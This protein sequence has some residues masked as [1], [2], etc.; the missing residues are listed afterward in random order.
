MDEQHTE[1]IGEVRENPDISV[2]DTSLND[3]AEEGKPLETQKKKFFLPEIKSKK[4]DWQLPEE[5][6]D[7]FKERCQSHMSDR[8]LEEF[9]EVPVPSNLDYPTKLDPFMKALL[10][11]K[12]LNKT[13]SVDDEMQKLHSRLFQIMGPLGKAWS[14][15]QSITQ[16]DEE[17]GPDPEEILKD[18]NSTIVLLGQTINKMAYE[19]RLSVL[20]AL[21]DAK[22]AKRQIKD[23]LDDINKEKKC[24]FGD[25]F[26]KHIKTL[27]KAQESA[28]KL[29]TKAGT[30]RK[31]P[32][33]NSR[34][35]LPSSSSNNSSYSSRTNAGGAS[36]SKN[37][38]GGF[39]WKRGK[40]VSINC[41]KHSN[42]YFAKSE[43]CK[44][45]SKKSLSRKTSRKLFR[46]GKIKEFLSELENNKFRP[47][48]L[49]NS[50]RLEVTHNRQTSSS[51]GA[52]RN[53]NVQLRATGSGQGNQNNAGKGCPE[54]GT[55][56]GKSVPVK[57][58]CQTQKRGEKISTNNKFETLEQVHA[59]HPFQNGG[60][61]ECNGSLKP[62]RLHDQD[63]SEGSLLACPNSQ[64][65]AEVS[66]FS[67]EGEIVRDAS[68]SFWNR[69]RTKNIYKIN[70]STSD[71]LEEI[72][73][74]DHCLPGR[75][76]N[77]KQNQGG[78]IGGQRFCDF[79]INPAGAHN[80]LGKISVDSN[81]GNRVSR[82]D[83]KQH[84]NENLVTNREDTESHRH[85]PECIEGKKVDCKVISQFNRETLLYSSCSLSSASMD[86]INATEPHQSST[87]T[88]GLRAGTVSIAG[89]DR[90]AQLVD[91]QFDA[92]E[93]L[94]N[95][96]RKPRNDYI[97]RCI[98]Q[99]GLGS[100]TGRRDINRGTLDKAGKNVPS[101]KRIGTTSRRNGNKNICK[102][103]ESKID[104]H[105]YRQHDST[106][107]L[108]QERGDKKSKTD[109]NIKKNLE[110][111][112]EPGNNANCIL[113]SITGEQTSRLEIPTKTELK[114]VGIV[115]SN[116]SQ[117]SRKM[118]E[119]RDRL[120][121]ITNNEK[122]ATV[123]VSESR[124]EL[125][126]NKCFV[127]KLGKFPL[128][129]PSI[130]SNRKSSQAYSSEDRRESDGHRTLMARTA[131][132]P[133]VA[134]IV[135]RQPN[136]SPSIAMC[137]KKSSRG[138][139]STI[140]KQDLS[141]CGL[142]SIRQQLEKKGISKGASEIMLKSKR[143]ST[144]QA[145]SSP[146]NKWVLWCKQQRVDPIDSP[147]NYILD[148][149][150]ELYHEGLQYRTINVYRSAI[151]AYHV[152]IGDIPVGQTK[153]VCT[154]LS[155]IDNLRPPVP[156]YTVIWEVEVVI[157]FLKT[158]IPEDD[159]SNKD[160]TLKVVMLMA[161]T[162]IKR[163]SELQMLD[164]QHMAVGE[165]KVIF[166]PSERPKNCKKKGG[167][168]PPVTFI[169]SGGEL[170]PV[171][172]IKSYLKRTNSW[173]KENSESKFFLSHI[174]PH[175]RVSASTIGRWL[176]TVLANVGVDISKF[177]A[178]SVRSASSSKVHTMGASV[179]E[180]MNCGNWNSSSTWQ[181]FYN[182]PVTSELVRAQNALLQ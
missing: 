85:L 68:S 142:S 104:T 156:K 179:K 42:N 25:E 20:S 96:A 130:L 87:E 48:N 139:T 150:T 155:G 170:C 165:N 63:R 23:N 171:A 58:I 5:L 26:Q 47:N 95:E 99:P 70:E 162:S 60:H 35:F 128:P 112:G 62:R 101:Y 77:Y 168:A 131:M 147:L 83:G 32:S 141:S 106:S 16:S 12:G 146:W 91:K 24:L 6:A 59:I 113:D 66:A 69:S 154:L 56:S 11:K 78:G 127:P 114:R 109:S 21:N 67:V 176:K 119:T 158:M 52:K 98:D 166:Q 49:G 27:T 2:S 1:D 97:L 102:E 61:E 93:G 72:I 9:L 118:G 145:Y 173:R 103:S 164:T 121:C 86:K 57:H 10:E 84:I 134:P 107:L 18:L 177:T 36:F 82:D 55:T 54:R 50:P 178:H 89:G 33:S 45:G 15:I 22:S 124:P 75:S 7:F 115:E 17:E 140:E 65:L 135:H 132:V 133:N 40:T 51:E 163:C 79:S 152:P 38:G 125:S 148:F 64:R 71:N 160:L 153:E 29:F 172:S 120:L 111:P 117:T 100:I 126:S 28:E 174:N 151:S 169:T 74:Q 144:T 161:L 105:I 43:T 13:L 90:R 92:I 37:R 76:A 137:T 81:T 53:S 143:E 3:Q 80:K 180:I 46:S 88:N 8:D 110:L 181:T 34:P 73:D 129:L 14:S 30:K 19:R 116:V 41:I 4:K 123:H 157:N 39:S 94:P 175:K 44:S 149:L 31:F 136:T 108:S 122:I 138:D 182:K 159:L 167:K